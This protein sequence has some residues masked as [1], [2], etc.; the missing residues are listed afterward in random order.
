MS[1]LKRTFKSDPKNDF[2]T[3]ETIA[4]REYPK[5]IVKVLPLSDSDFEWMQWRRKRMCR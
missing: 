2:A 4:Q 5:T 3:D 1:F